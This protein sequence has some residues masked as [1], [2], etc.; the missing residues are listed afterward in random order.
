MIIFC[1]GKLKFPVEGLGLWVG[2][3]GFKNLAVGVYT[4]AFRV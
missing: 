4:L 2:G 3:L 1:L